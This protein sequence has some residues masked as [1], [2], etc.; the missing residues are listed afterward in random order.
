MTAGY[1]QT[2]LPKKLGMKPGLRAL[3]IEAPDNFEDLLG[4]LDDVELASGLR[5]KR[6][7]D[8][9]M[10]FADRLK[11]LHAKLLPAIAR[12]DIQGG[13]WVCWPKKASGA[14]TDI[15]ETHVR[16]AGLDAG[17][18]DVKICAVDET[19][20]GLRFCYRKEDRR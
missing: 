7:A 2:P 12:L 18:V 4:P 19:W 14:K 8:V 9:V 10:L 1:S 5:S 11:V 15:T 20:S 16:T 6:S 3:L 17:L 13:L